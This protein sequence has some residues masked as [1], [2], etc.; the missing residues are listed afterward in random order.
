MQKLNTEVVDDLFFIVLRCVNNNRLIEV[1]CLY[2]AFIIFFNISLENIVVNQGLV[3]IPI[4]KGMFNFM[5]SLRLNHLIFLRFFFHLS[6]VFNLFDDFARL[7]CMLLYL[8][9]P[10]LA[11]FVQ[12]DSKPR[13]SWWVVRILAIRVKV[14]E[15]IA[16]HTIV[17]A[18]E[19]FLFWL[20][21]FF[22]L[23]LS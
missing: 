8:A 6:M 9:G 19:K 5:I 7:C 2:L 23:A 3:L 15:I 13:G 17:E 21:K 11:H 20:V 18:F 12:N 4:V 10:V 22:T 16:S 1:V 14:F